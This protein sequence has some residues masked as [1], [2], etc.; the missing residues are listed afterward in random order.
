[1]NLSIYEWPFQ[2][3][4]YMILLSKW[5]DIHVHDMPRVSKL[6]YSLLQIVKAN[7]GSVVPLGQQYYQTSQLL[8][9]CAHHFDNFAQKLKVVAINDF[10]AVV[11]VEDGHMMWAVEDLSEQEQWAASFDMTETDYF[12]V[13]VESLATA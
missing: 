4:K 12:G 6:K 13:V 10:V 1:M 9:F 3:K 5:C 2:L 11:V 7:Y 8:W